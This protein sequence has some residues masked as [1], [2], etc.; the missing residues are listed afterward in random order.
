MSRV[1]ESLVNELL[2]RTSALPVDQDLF[3]DPSLVRI[4]VS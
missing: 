2:S 3:D 1:S 4:R